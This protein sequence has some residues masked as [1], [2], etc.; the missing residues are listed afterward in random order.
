LRAG[1]KLASYRVLAEATQRLDD[2]PWQLIV[3]GDGAVRAEVERLFDQ[4]ACF[5]GSLRQRRIAEVLA[6][7]DLCAWAGL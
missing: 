1:D 7:S 5:L 4:R 2:L 6:A 3:C